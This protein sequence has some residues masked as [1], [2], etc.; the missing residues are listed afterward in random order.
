[1]DK[2]I[3]I[4]SEE[5][6]MYTGIR[7]STSNEAILRGVRL[8]MALGFDSIKMKNSTI[9]V[10]Q[11]E[12]EI[13]MSGLLIIDKNRLNTSIFISDILLDNVSETTDVKVGSPK[14]FGDPIEE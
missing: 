3:Y 9:Q 12:K 6:V 8:A 2:K 1:M 5:G 11:E 7:I 4:L 14:P 13:Q 10:V